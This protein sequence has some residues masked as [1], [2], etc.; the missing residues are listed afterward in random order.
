MQPETAQRVGRTVRRQ[1]LAVGQYHV[2]RLLLG[3][4]AQEVD[5]LYRQPPLVPA[6]EPPL[7]GVDT[8]EQPEQTERYP[9]FRSGTSVGL[10]PFIAAFGSLISSDSQR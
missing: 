1:G 7:V 4:T 3:L 6:Q 2:L 8:G 10:V 5:R 9:P